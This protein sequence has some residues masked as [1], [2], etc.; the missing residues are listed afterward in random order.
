MDRLGIR[1]KWN[2]NITTKRDLTEVGR[3]NP[4]QYGSETVGSTN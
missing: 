2:V 4:Y 3:T 1:G